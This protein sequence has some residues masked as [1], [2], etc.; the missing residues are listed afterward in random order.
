MTLHYCFDCTTIVIDSSIELYEICL[1][2]TYILCSFAFFHPFLTL[3]SRDNCVSLHGAVGAPARFRRKMTGIVGAGNMSSTTWFTTNQVSYSNHA[4]LRCC[5][6]RASARLH[7]SPYPARFL[8]PSFL[9]CVYQLVVN[10]V[11][12]LFCKPCYQ[13]RPCLIIGDMPNSKEFF[14]QTRQIFA[15]ILTD[16]KKI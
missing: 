11:F 10:H 15:G 16:G 12:G 4:R 6:W 1:P 3:D 14:C 13:T 9:P 7:P 2:C 5:L 8:L